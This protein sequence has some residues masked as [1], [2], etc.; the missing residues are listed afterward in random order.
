MIKEMWKKVKNLDTPFRVRLVIVLTA[1]YI[2]N[3]ID[4]IPDFIPLL[5]QI[6]DIVIMTFAIKYIKKHIDFD[7]RKII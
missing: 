2:L 6:D 3:P 4:L 5:G 1:L 7:V